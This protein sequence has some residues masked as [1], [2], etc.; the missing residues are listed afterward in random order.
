MIKNKILGLSSKM[1]FRLKG[2]SPQILLGVGIV[3]L[4]ATVVMACKATLKA[5]PI[6]EDHNREIEHI[7]KEDP[8]N[9]KALV[10]EYFDTAFDVC[11][12]YGPSFITGI[13]SFYCI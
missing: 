10:K 7:K 2:K 6:L 1:I 3:G 5:E 13:A 11:K 8:E 4:T 12:L 9:K